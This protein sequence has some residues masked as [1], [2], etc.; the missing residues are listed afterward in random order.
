MMMK[1]TSK[2]LITRLMLIAMIALGVCGGYFVSK[3][4]P[5]GLLLLISGFI[6]LF[7]K[8]RLEAM[9]EL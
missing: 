3:E 9:W 2:L 6:V 5:L 8:W 4:N 7:S 1:R